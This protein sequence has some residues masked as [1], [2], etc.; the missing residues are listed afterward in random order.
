MIHPYE[1]KE[2]TV[3]QVKDMVRGIFNGEIELTEK[4]DGM[5]IQVT[6]NTKGEVVFLR[7]KGDLNSLNGGMTLDQMKVKWADNPDVMNTFV[8][9]GEILIN[10]LKGKRFS[11]NPRCDLK[12][13]LNCECVRVG[14][15]NVM[16]Y[17]KSMVIVHNIW[18]YRRGEQ[19]WEKVCESTRG[20][21]RIIGNGVD[22]PV[23]LTMKSNECDD[24]IVRIEEVLGREDDRT[25]DYCMWSRYIHLLYNNEYYR[26]ILTSHHGCLALYLRW[27][28]NEKTI[29]LKELKEIYRDNIPALSGIESSKGRGI[30]TAVTK[31][32][33][34]LFVEIGQRVMGSVTGYINEGNDDVVEDLMDDFEYVVDTIMESGNEEQ[35]Y[36]V[37]YQLRR[38]RGG[39]LP[40]EGVVFKWNGMLMKLTGNFAPLN[41]IMGFNKFAR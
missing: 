15:T 34:D 13:T 17:G 3:G 27:F 1:C 21:N 20:L 39:F 16:P 41:Q 14:K 29:N 28:W 9:A 4:V 23:K 10:A 2:L 19:G 12:Y 22:G 36:K 35:I 24:L 40:I 33:D 18:V 32:I 30:V 7:N 38:M 8:S 5:N 25:I 37:D 6:V 26:W 31:D 11:F